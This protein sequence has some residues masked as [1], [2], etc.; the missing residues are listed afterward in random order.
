[1][2]NR[3]QRRLL[4]TAAKALGFSG[5][6]D[7]SAPHAVRARAPHAHR[8]VSN[9][10]GQDD[11]RGD[12]QGEGTLLS[13]SADPGTTAAP[14]RPALAFALDV[15]TPGDVRAWAKA[16]H[17]SCEDVHPGLMKCAGVPDARA[18]T[19]D[20]L[21]LGFDTGGHMVNVSTLRQHLTPSAAAESA[22]DITAS[23]RAELGG[24]GH[25]TGDFDAAHLS[26]SGAYSTATVSYRFAPTTSRT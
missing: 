7:R 19:I 15:T 26:R 9:G 5:A 2:K 21:A 16:A 13:V 25:A 6:R 1:M 18:G 23:L 3:L 12:G 4:T 8:R 11:A 20:E 24:S 14:A 17:V 10:R 22:R